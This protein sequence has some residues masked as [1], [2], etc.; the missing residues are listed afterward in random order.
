MKQIFQIHLLTILLI[1]NVFSYE[2][3]FTYSSSGKINLQHSPEFSEISGGYTRIAK[4]GE[5]HTIEP[6]MPE[7]PHFSTYFQLDPTKTYDFQFEILDSYIIEDIT[8][9]P[10]QDMDKWEVNAVSI[11][12]ET[13]YDSYEPLPEV[14]MVVSE[15]MQGRGV[16]FVS[17][18]VTPYTYYLYS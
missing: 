3:A 13:V 11:I 14:N 2:N 17:I 6:G 10:H 12:N 15:R 18:N 5:G 4:M 1:S 7:L 16:E 9:M 8:I